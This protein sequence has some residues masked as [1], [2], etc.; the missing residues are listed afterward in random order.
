MLSLVSGVV[1][2]VFGLLKFFSPF[3][4]WYLAQIE[5]SGLPQYMYAVGIAGEIITG[6]AF[7]LPFLVLMNDR[8]KH[9]LLI[10]ANCLMISIMVAATVVHLIR[11]VPSG[12]LPLKIKPPVIPIMFMA[13]AVFNLTNLNYLYRRKDQHSSNQ[14]SLQIQ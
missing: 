1:S 14:K 8:S 12:V 13:I 4:D 10:L 2:L 7:F 3:R 5:S 11:W 6:V 9:L